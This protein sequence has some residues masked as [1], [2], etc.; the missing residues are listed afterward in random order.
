M[1]LTDPQLFIGTYSIILLPSLLYIC[2][3]NIQIN[4][5]Y[6]ISKLD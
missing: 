2:I 6:L 1:N 3:Y 4:I 5:L